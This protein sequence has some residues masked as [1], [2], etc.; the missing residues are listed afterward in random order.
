[1]VVNELAG[2]AEEIVLV[3]DDYHLIEAPTVHGSLA[4]LLERLP[5]Q[6]RLVLASRADPSL[7]LAR[8]RV[9]GQLT[10]IRE[11]DLR[12][13]AEETAAL[14]REATGAGPPRRHRGRPRGPNRGVG[15]RAPAR[16]PVPAG[17]RRRGRFVA[18]FT[19]SHRYVLDYLTEEVLARQPQELVRFL[20]ETSVLQRL[21]GP[22]CDAVTGRDDG[23]QLLEQIERANLFLVPWT[24]S[25]LVALP[26]AIRRPAPGPPLQADPE[27]VAELHRAA[28]GWCER[29]GWVT[30][31]SP[32]PWPPTTP[33]GRPG[34]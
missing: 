3:L 25:G 19:G 13:T 21:S 23:Q 9:G 12:F 31:L 26:P 29:T 24:T 32:T 18:T 10:E 7:P 5:P 1:M 16:R 4:L 6:L 20:L 28:A 27:R 30:T 14:L 34:W 11:A 22:L 2:V 8:L 17:S 15:R 33:S